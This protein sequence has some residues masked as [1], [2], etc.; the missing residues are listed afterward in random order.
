[1]E[2]TRKDY[3]EIV[4][5]YILKR[6][7]FW[8][9]LEKIKDYIKD[10]DK[11]LDFGCGHGRLLLLLKDKKIDYIGT[12]ISLKILEI[13]KKRF[14]NRDFRIVNKLSLPFSDSFFNAICCIA[15]FHHIPSAKLR[16]RLLRE[17]KRALKQDGFLILTIWYLWV[18][19][20][21]L[22]LKYI[23]KWFLSKISGK[24]TELDFKDV[25]IPWKNNEGK[26][27]ANRYLHAFTKNELAT[28]VK[29]AGFKIEKLEIVKRSKN[30]ANI[31]I[32]AT[33]P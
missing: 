21:R 31:L 25:F 19:Q 1:M 13:A 26:T 20:R 4:E 17:F 32:V 8:P 16:L 7:F 33:K 27:L 15:V 18:G 24:K 29:K 10:G 5:S 12:D 9:E 6:Q 3:D 2:K 22:V 30:L 14:P 23:S 28:L 11:I